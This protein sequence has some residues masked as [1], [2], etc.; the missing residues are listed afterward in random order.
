VVVR[1]LK[2]RNPQIIYYEGELL[3]WLIRENEIGTRYQAHELLW[4]L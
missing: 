1:V 4:N 2:I 3:V